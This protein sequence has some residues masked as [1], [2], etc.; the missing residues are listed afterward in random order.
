MDLN[1]APEGQEAEIENEEQEEETTQPQ[2][3]ES[4]ASMKDLLEDEGVGLDFPRQGEI[5][6][7]TVARVTETEILVSIGTKSEGVILSREVEQIEPELREELSIG[8]EITVYVVN[9]EDQ[10]GNILLSYVRALE[11]KDWLFT[12]S[13]LASGETYEGTII[14]FN[15]GGLIIPV[16]Q[17]R[18]FVPASQVSLLR[19]LD[20]TGNTPEQRWGPMVDQPITVSVIEVDR[21][22][23]RLILS[24]RA[25]LQETRESL[26]ERLLEELSEGD[27]RT[28]R[29]T[30]LADFGAFVNIDGADGLVHLSEISWERIEHPREVLKVGQEVEVK[31]IGVDRER[32]RI[33]LSIRQLQEDPWVKKIENLK[34]GQLIEGTIT[35]LTKFGAFA[36][37]DEDLEGLIHISEISEQRVGH[38][39]EVLHEGDVVTL[40][41]IKIEPERHRIG[42]SLRKVDSPAY[43]DFDWKMT[44]AEVVEEAQSEDEVSF[45][46]AV[47]EEEAA[48]EEVREQVEV[49]P[50]AEGDMGEEEAP[51]DVEASVEEVPEQETPVEAETSVEEVLEVEEPSNEAEASVEEVLEV[52]EPSTEVEA[53]VE[54]TPEEEPPVE[55]EASVEEVPEVE[56]TST[57]VEASV[58]EVPEQETPVEAET[59]VEEVLEVEEPSNEAEA[60]VEEMPVE[61]PPVEA[62]VSVEEVSEVEEPSNEAEASIEEM[63]EEEPPIETESSTE[64]ELVDEESDVTE[65]DVQAEGGD[66]P[67]GALLEAE[68]EA[69]SEEVEAPVAEAESAEEAVGETEEPENTNNKD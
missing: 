33:G 57:E 43:T 59:S 61:E 32:K 44:L 38:P 65:E 2:T 40:R 51:G 52:E 21:E 64:E 9:P 29:V 53:S 50:S 47:S 36:R 6:Q 14:G 63:L 18:G 8:K 16:G 55:A 58:E 12:E 41:V 3:P 15:K 23:R 30:S 17:L 19:R 37:L 28:G 1:N 35:H 68:A 7:G 11:E 46:G 42:L 66:S 60:S 45:E 26:K 39:K 34:E 48:L 54:E 24:E 27:I 62:E 13:L 22:R 20:S 25:A 31:V 49:E 69:L 5:R 10:N 56:E 4:Q 67:E